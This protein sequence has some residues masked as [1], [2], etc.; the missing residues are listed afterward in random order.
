MET[1]PHDGGVVSLVRGGCSEE[2]EVTPRLVL[3]I[4][5][6]LGGKFPKYENEKFIVIGKIAGLGF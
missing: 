4:K 6:S 2:K 3:V 5:F 1:A